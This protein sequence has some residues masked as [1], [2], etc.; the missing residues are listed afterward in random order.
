MS[1]TAGP[2]VRSG[3]RMFYGRLKTACSLD[4]VGFLR[5]AAIILSVVIFFPA[6]SSASDPEVIGINLNLEAKGDFF[7]LRAADGDFFIRAEDLKSMGFRDPT[8]Q[9]AMIAGELYLSIRSMAGVVYSYNP[10]TLSL[11]I[12]APPIFLAK[13]T[14]DFSYQ[15][16]ETFYYPEES[17][18][19][20]N[21]RLS[22]SGTDSA[23]KG[24]DLTNQVGIRWGKVLFQ[25]D[26]IFSQTPGAGNFNR[27][28][29][30]FTIDR[31]EDLRRT[32]IGDFQFSSGNLGGNVIL[33][34]VSFAKIHRIDPYFL[35]Y[36]AVN[37]TGFLPTPSE[38]D[39]YL[40]GTKIRTEKLPPGEFE[41][42][43]FY[44]TSGAGVVEFVIRDPFG[45]EQRI[46][47]PFYLS[48][49]LLKA[50]LHEFSYNLGFIRENFASADDRYTKPAFSGFHRYGRSDALTL[51]ISGE[52]S[53]DFVNVAPHVTTL[54]GT[55]GVVN[56]AIAVS[57]GATGRNGLA[58]VAEY[59]YNKRQYS[60]RALLKGF[61]RDYATIDN[62]AAASG[63]RYELSLGG[64]IGTPDYGS[65]SLDLA[66]VGR[67]DLKNQSL[68]TVN[69]SRRLAKNLDMF[70]SLRITRGD[71]ADNRLFA[72]INYSLG[73]DNMV[74]SWADIG[75]TSDKVLVQIQKNAP[76]GEG[77]GYRT[78][79]ER[80]SSSAG[81]GYALNPALQYNSRY[82]IYTADVRGESSAGESAAA[83]QLTAAGALA[84]TGDTFA[85]TR[86]I[87]DSFAVIKVGDLQGVRVYQNSQEAGRTDAS[88]KL[89]I[90]NLNSFIDN[91][92]SI[93][94]KDIPMEYSLATILKHISPPFRS[95]SCLLFQVARQQPII[96]TLHLDQEGRIIPLEFLEARVVLGNR[97]IVIPTGKGGEFY[98]DPSQQAPLPA[99]LVEPGCEAM[100]GAKEKELKPLQLNGVIEFQGEK[101]SFSLQLPPSAELFIDLGKVVIKDR[102]LPVA[103][104]IGAGQ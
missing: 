89:V 80:S 28:L 48:D 10:T 97:E 90:V 32:V 91:Q 38:V 1:Q 13:R 103:D 15:R 19:Y 26:A 65:F 22:Y 95:G 24:L 37:Q 7:V 9:P 93:N 12:T 104:R 27:L 47:R 23:F 52:A 79:I 30:N 11:D 62:D 50:G 45:K 6:V 60:A 69:Y 54:L 67:Y 25:S 49:R 100:D 88:G 75:N 44:T 35:S 66:L 63:K 74:S 82:G 43:N 71:E 99:G 84:H 39:I 77:L 31:R 98:L 102:P 36:P 73:K 3:K 20:L 2:R 68:V 17:S 94:D 86:P 78:S 96:G 61:S 40:D 33:G 101:Y 16:Q 21:Y 4:S 8:G 34:G 59:G 29:S 56:A 55:A 76:T 92:I 18:A 64:G 41:L 42:K 57:A 5:L 72:G 83:Y 87:N 51:G 14:I 58:G 81:T 85:F 53:I 70:A 46:V